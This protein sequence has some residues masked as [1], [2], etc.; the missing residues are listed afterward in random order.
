MRLDNEYILSQNR[1]YNVQ[2]G[3]SQ[4]GTQKTISPVFFWG[5]V[6]AAL[7]NILK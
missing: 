1:K 5:G 7:G 3:K 4:I 6:L 2:F